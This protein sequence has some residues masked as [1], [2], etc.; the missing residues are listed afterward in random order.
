MQFNSVGKGYCR[1]EERGIDYN[2]AKI[3]DWDIWEVCE[4][5]GKSIGP[6][7]GIHFDSSPTCVDRSTLQQKVL[8]LHSMIYITYA[9]WEV[10]I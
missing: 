10:Y 3:L 8:Q 7:D 6:P 1:I 4:G 5:G 9:V 2:K